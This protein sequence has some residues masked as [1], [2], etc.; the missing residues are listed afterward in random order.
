MLGYLLA[1]RFSTELLQYPNV[2]ICKLAEKTDLDLYKNL[3]SFL[4]VIGKIPAYKPGGPGS[5]PGGVRYFNFYPGNGCVYFIRVP[6]CVVFGGG[7]D[8]LLIS[9]SGRPA[10]MY[11]SS[12]VVHS[13]WFS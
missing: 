2:Y 5:I 8:I 12:V 7:P 1:I 9:D 4:G 11:L 6:S 10:F 13:L 3:Q